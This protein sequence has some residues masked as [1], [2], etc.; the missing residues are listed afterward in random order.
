VPIQIFTP[1]ARLAKLFAGN[2][3]L[4]AVGIWLLTAGF[5]VLF[6]I[7]GAACVVAFGLGLVFFGSRLIRP[8]PVLQIDGFGV[9]DRSSAVAL[10][11]LR[12][13]EIAGV[14]IGAVEVNGRSR[15]MLGI[16]PVPTADPLRRANPVKAFLLRA[17]M[18][19]GLS[20]VTIAESSLPFSLETAIEQMRRF[21]PNLAVG[22]TVDPMG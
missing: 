3:V 4:V 14:K 21:W 1:R 2:L 13:E 22:S 11:L 17:N 20:P 18:R 9:T 16:Y 6:D 15:R 10:G 5:S 8:V 12:W 19:M 7:A